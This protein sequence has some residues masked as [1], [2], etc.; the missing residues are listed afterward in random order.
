MAKP[1]RTFDEHNHLVIAF[2]SAMLAAQGMAQAALMSDDF[3]AWANSIFLAWGIPSIW[4]M[5]IAMFPLSIWFQSVGLAAWRAAFERGLVRDPVNA[6][7]GAVI[8]LTS[9]LVSAAAALV[10]FNAA[11]LTQR[12]VQDTMAPVAT[13]LIA[14]EAD[15]TGIADAFAGLAAQAKDLALAETTQGNTCDGQ[16]TD[17][18]A[19]PRARKRLRDE[20]DLDGMA[21]TADSLA[22][23]GTSVRLLLQT[24]SSAEAEAAVGQA[25]GLLRSADMNGLR[26]DL[27]RILVELEDSFVDPD[28][29]LTYVC[30]TPAFE[31]KLKQVSDSL[32]RIVATPLPVPTTIIEEQQG[33]GAGLG[34]VMA[35]IS[36][37]LFGSGPWR[38]PGL[39]S[40]YGALFFE[41][42]Q[43]VL[44]AKSVR[45][46]RRLRLLPSEA[47]IIE[48]AQKGRRTP[49]EA[50]DDQML[51]KAFQRRM[52]RQR[53]TVYAVTS[54]EPDDIER[55]IILHFGLLPAMGG[56]HDVPI[57]TL[58]PAWVED[59]RDLWP[60]GTRFDVYEIPAVAFRNF[61]FRKA[62]A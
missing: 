6:A 3:R 62:A 23:Q 32:D 14:L 31:A 42:L 13:E 16:Q 2:I 45:T 28:T 29:G 36:A 40:L 52:W 10:V 34:A 11:M 49:Q 4:A 15:L 59:H 47:E 50:A 30:R 38:T 57:G 48:D 33:W 60:V 25:Q 8:S 12:A 43:V 5:T 18:K 37:W 55:R 19:G 39:I 46:R 54:T 7:T 24:G 61:W 22:A 1:R 56:L 17:P 58:D 35:D 21:L 51:V 44:L 20:T 53:N 27:Q 9:A 41:T 26:R